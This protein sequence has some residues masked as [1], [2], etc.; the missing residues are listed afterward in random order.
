MFHIIIGILIGVVGFVIAAIGAFA[1]MMSDADGSGMQ[2]LVYASPGI[3]IVAL[4][5]AI[6]IWG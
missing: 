4:G 3:A 5:A 6:A 2:Q 1:V